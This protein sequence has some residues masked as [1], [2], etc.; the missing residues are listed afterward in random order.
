M[1]PRVSPRTVP[2]ATGRSPDV[3]A[4][5]RGRV[6][7]QA[8]QPGGDGLDDGDRSRRHVD[9]PDTQTGD[10]APAQP[11][12]VTEVHHRPELTYAAEGLRQPGEIGASTT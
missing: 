7:H 3:V 8:A 4:T 10:L 5:A 6:L 12:D 1:V 11:L 9:L 2:T